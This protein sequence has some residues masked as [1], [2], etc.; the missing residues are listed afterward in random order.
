MILNKRSCMLAVHYFNWRTSRFSAQVGEGLFWSDRI[1]RFQHSRILCERSLRCASSRA[2]SI[3]ARA[4]LKLCDST[5]FENVVTC[6][7]GSHGLT[8]SKFLIVRSRRIPGT[9]T[10]ISLS[11]Q[12][13]CQI[14]LVCNVLACCR[15]ILG[16]AR[17]S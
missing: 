10:K 16:C 1:S 17:C 7:S 15:M 14:F 9:A 2:L 6:D 13:A 3:T 12:Y 8:C 11:R 5:D 4:S